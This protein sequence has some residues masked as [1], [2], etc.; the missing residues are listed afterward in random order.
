MPRI[1]GE[2][3]TRASAN[4]RE[5]QMCS[6]HEPSRKLHSN[7]IHLEDGHGALRGGLRGGIRE[8]LRGSRARAALHCERLQQ[9]PRG[10]FLNHNGVAL[11]EGSA[12]GEGAGARTVAASDLPTHHTQNS[13]DTR[14]TVRETSAEK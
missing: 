12:G 10:R 4:T 13:K 9:R 6:H 3:R 7:T 5:A 11:D 2:K 8:R 1:V 14:I